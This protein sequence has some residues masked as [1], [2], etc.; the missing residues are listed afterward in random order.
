MKIHLLLALGGL[1]FSFAFPVVAQQTAD[2]KTIE[3]FDEFNKKFDEAFNNKD[4]AAVAAFFTEDAVQVTPEGPIYGRDA[5]Q[6][7]Y[8]GALQ[9]FF[10]VTILARPTRIPF[11]L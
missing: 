1:A 11:A 4:A 5:I 7:W 10:S 6:K 3:Q 2:P 8:E 9:Q